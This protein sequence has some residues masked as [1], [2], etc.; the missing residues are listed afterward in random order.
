MKKF[1]VA[2]STA[3]IV[4]VIAFAAGSSKSVKTS[5]VA[6]TTSRDSFED[7]FAT[8]VK[9]AVPASGNIEI[10]MFERRKYEPSNRSEN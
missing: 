4:V 7:G 2:V 3:T 8:T 9:C 6:A 1:Q 5:Q 10:A